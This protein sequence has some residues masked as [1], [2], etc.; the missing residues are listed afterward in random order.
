ML[1]KVSVLDKLLQV[2]VRSAKTVFPGQ[3]DSVQIKVADYNNKPTANVN[4]TVFS[5][6]NQFSKQIRVNDPPYLKKYINRPQIQYPNFEISG[7]N[8][9]SNF[10][11]GKH[12]LF[13]NKLGLDSLLY[14]QV[15]F[16]KDTMMHLHQPI[17]NAFPQVSVHIVKKGVPQAIYLLYLNNQLVY[18]HGTTDESQYAFEGGYGYTK[19]GIRLRDSY[20]EIDSI[21]LQPYYKHDLIFD[22][23]NLPI[24]ARSITQPNYYSTAEKAMLSRQL[25]TIENQGITNKTLVW[26]GNKAFRLK[27]SGKHL[28]GPF[29][30]EDSLHTI[31]PNA[32]R[33][34]YKFEPGYS[35]RLSDKVIRLEKNELFPF[36]KDPYYLPL[37]KNVFL[38]LGD[39]ILPVENMLPKTTAS[40]EKNIYYFLNTT[41]V[42]SYFSKLNSTIP[43]GHI[44]F[45]LTKDTLYEYVII[46]SISDTNFLLIDKF[47]NYRMAYYNLPI[48]KYQLLLVMKNL[49]CSVSDRFEIKP[50]KTLLIRFNNKNYV[51]NLP[52]LNQ[53]FNEQNKKKTPIIVPEPEPESEKHVIVPSYIAGETVITGTVTD[54]KGKLPI[55]GVTVLL[56]GT[57]IATITDSY[58][59]YTLQNIGN[60]VNTI[61]FSSVGYDTKEMPAIVLSPTTLQLNVSLTVTSVELN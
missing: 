4:L 28:I 34:D 55:S 25:I 49:S 58:G 14:Y 21:Y 48:G 24:S 45:S 39:T 54:A 12:R 31:V 29:L 38:H 1:Q 50:F 19:L 36:R 46:K 5:Y 7:A 2:D 6:N 11:L 59:K 42:T 40:N 37:L 41:N 47:N 20:V 22:L 35:Y 60:G 26:Q 17:A 23:D 51:S 3:T 61:V 16:P 27:S 43:K 18:Y 15:L 32:Y 44:Q 8:Y 30:P 56:K 9:K 33:I 53:L 52:F 57:K 10:S 13:I